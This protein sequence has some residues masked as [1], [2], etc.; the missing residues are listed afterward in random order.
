V[1]ALLNKS[2]KSFQSVAP[3]AE[4]CPGMKLHFSGQ[5]CGWKPCFLFLFFMIVF[6]WA[7]RLSR[8][9][10]SLQESSAFSYGG[11]LTQD[12]GV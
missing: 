10:F 9:K 8:V 2:E 5:S 12:C 6:Y 1:I 11:S 4:Y 3:V 7:K